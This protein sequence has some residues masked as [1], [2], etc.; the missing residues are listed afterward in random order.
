MYISLNSVFVHTQ[1]SPTCKMLRVG[2]P[3]E[4][5]SSNPLILYMRTGQHREVKWWGQAT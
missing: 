2:K 4:T 3:L 5:Y 1:S